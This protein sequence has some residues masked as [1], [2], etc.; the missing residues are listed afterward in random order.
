MSSG[1]ENSGK[2]SIQQNNS[3]RLPLVLLAGSMI[4]FG[5]QTPTP[6]LNPCFPEWLNRLRQRGDPLLA[7][8]NDYTKQA[9]RIEPN[10]SAT[11]GPISG[12]MQQ[13]CGDSAGAIESFFSTLVVSVNP[14]MRRILILFL[15]STARTS[16]RAQEAVPVTLLASEKAEQERIRLGAPGAAG[17]TY[18]ALRE[19]S[20]PWLQSGKLACAP[21]L[22]IPNSARHGSRQAS[23]LSAGWKMTRAMIE[24][25]AKESPFSGALSR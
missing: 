25:K 3:A 23:P 5:Q 11:T 19:V 14:S 21:L 9:V 24:K 16:A 12:L 7:A 15:G 10:M 2:P 20:H 6:K 17:R 18:I 4:G 13:E 8:A 1:Q 22:S